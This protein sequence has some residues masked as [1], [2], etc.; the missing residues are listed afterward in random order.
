MLDALTAAALP[1]S[2]RQA[3][4]VAQE[5]T[6]ICMSSHGQ[7]APLGCLSGHSCIKVSRKEDSNPYLA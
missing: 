7:L 5:Y 4:T 3:G 2:C 6:S 1:L